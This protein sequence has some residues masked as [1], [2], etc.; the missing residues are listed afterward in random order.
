MSKFS[1]SRQEKSW[2]LYD[3]AN[4]AFVL[5]VVTAVM[6]IFFKEYASQGVAP[7]VSTANWGFAN[8]L[9]SMVV[10]IAAP[11]LGT[12]ADGEGLKKRF[13]TAFLVLGLLATFQQAF[14][15]G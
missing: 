13:F 1:F 10:A 2:I 9:A 14:D 7:S 5:V 8:G 15:L 4:S 3:V 12:F 11:V 6:P